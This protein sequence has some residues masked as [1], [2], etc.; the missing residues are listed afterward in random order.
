MELVNNIFPT[1]KPI[2]LN[3][4][5]NVFYIIKRFYIIQTIYNKEINVF[6]YCYLGIIDFN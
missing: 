4:I 6:W 5:E 1:S 3:I 2:S